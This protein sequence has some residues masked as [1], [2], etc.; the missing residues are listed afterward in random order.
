MKHEGWPPDGDSSLTPDRS[1]SLLLQRYARL[2]ST[3][4]LPKGMI[5]SRDGDRIWSRHVLDGFRGAELIPGGANAVADLGSGAGIPGIPVA[6]G[7]PQLAITLSEPRRERVAF[8]ELVVTELGLGNVTVH[9][10]RAQ[11][12]P[13][14]MDVCLARAFRGAQETWSLAEHLLAPAGVLLFW[15]GLR[16]RIDVSGA[17]MRAFSA[18]TLADAGPV[19]MMTRR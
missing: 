2:L 10:G 11:T 3:V 9:A 16:A 6:I 14:G 17:R 1:Q 18:P 7:R 5:S 12:L 15:A 4:A 8:L 13:S 19:V